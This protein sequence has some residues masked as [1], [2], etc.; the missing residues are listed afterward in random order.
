MAAQR[1]PV[2]LQK[3]HHGAD[4]VVDGK[5]IVPLH[6]GFE[7]RLV[8]PFGKLIQIALLIVVVVVDSHPAVDAASERKTVAHHL[9]T[10]RNAGQRVAGGI[11]QFQGEVAL[12]DGFDPLL[13]FG[14]PGGVRF[15]SRI[16]EGGDR[17]PFRGGDAFVL[18]HF[19]A[20]Q[21]QGLGTVGRD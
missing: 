14:A 17:Q 13:G 9:H 6:A 19:D 21:F 7:H 16:I 3:F 15:A 12:A 4:L 1:N 5:S 10:D 20:G 11:F 8:E 2:L 18:H